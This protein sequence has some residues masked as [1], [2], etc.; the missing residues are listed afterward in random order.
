MWAASQLAQPCIRDCGAPGGLAY[1]CG[2]GMAE[3]DGGIA[4]AVLL[5]PLQQKLYAY[6][7]PDV[8]GVQSALPHGLL[9]LQFL[10]VA[11]QGPGQVALLAPTWK[12]EL[13]MVGWP[14]RMHCRVAAAQRRFGPQLCFAK[15]MLLLCNTSQMRRLKVDMLHL[16]DLSA[17]MLSLSQQ[18]QGLKVPA[19]QSE[20]QRASTGYQQIVVGTCWGA[21]QA[22]VAHNQALL[23]QT[24][25]EGGWSCRDAPTRP[26]HRS[27]AV[28]DDL[29]AA[30]APQPLHDGLQAPNKAAAGRAAGMQATM[31]STTHSRAARCGET[32]KLSCSAWRI[33]SH[34]GREMLTRQR[35]LV[36]Q[37]WGSQAGPVVLLQQVAGQG[38]VESRA[39]D[40]AISGCPNN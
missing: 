16:L 32:G 31:H 6:G 29:P 9:K 5:H 18:G 39:W 36:S 1:P 37:L 14:V 17:G 33:G 4:S 10:V 24:G 26:E 11:P 7:L 12:L 3:H 34:P 2:H 23:S 8:A 25:H 21:L 30:D 22:G 27:P 19:S 20:Y 13:C 40:A 35:D 28:G 38:F 15:T